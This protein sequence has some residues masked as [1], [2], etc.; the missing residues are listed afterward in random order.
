[1]QDTVERHARLDP[2]MEKIVQREQ[3]TPATNGRRMIDDF[4]FRGSRRWSRTNA[5]P[6]KPRWRTGVARDFNHPN[7]FLSEGGALAVAVESFP[8]ASRAIKASVMGEGVRKS[9]KEAVKWYREAAEQGEADAPLYLGFM[10]ANA[11]GVP[12][13]WAKAYSWWIL[14]ADQGEEMAVEGKDRLK[15]AMTT[16]ITD[17]S[18]GPCRR[19]RGA[20]RL[21]AIGTVPRLPIRKSILG[22]AAQATRSGQA[23]TCSLRAGDQTPITLNS[24]LLSRDLQYL[25]GHANPRTIEI[26]EYRAEISV[27]GTQPERRQESE[28]KLQELSDR[29]PNRSKLDDR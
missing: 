1:M 8:V 11:K 19:V 23:G 25:A 28:W 26:D 12:K 29:A 15:S 2:V 6:K 20:H 16:T 24:D 4:R 9:F 14:A 17:C 27:F 5:P 3:E 18:R 21:L 22:S 13:D 10:Y 7:A